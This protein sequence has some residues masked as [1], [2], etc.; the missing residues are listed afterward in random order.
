MR[1][2]GLGR[3]QLRYRYLL[4]PGHCN[5]CSDMRCSTGCLG[6]RAVRCLSAA[7]QWLHDLHGSLAAGCSPGSRPACLWSSVTSAVD[8][9]CTLAI[10]WLCCLPLSPGVVSSEAVQGDVHRSVWAPC[11]QFSRTAQ[12]LCGLLMHGKE[13]LCGLHPQSSLPRFNVTLKS[14]GYS[15]SIICTVCPT[16]RAPESL[17]A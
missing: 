5:G 3:M 10:I 17:L 8:E 4:V 7:P 9:N 1:T 2:T 14:G 6:L 12:L 13:A 15:W 11:Q 16:F